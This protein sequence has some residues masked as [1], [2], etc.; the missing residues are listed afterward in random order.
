MRRGASFVS[1]FLFAASVVLSVSAP[2]R[3]ADP[4]DS[5]VVQVRE[6]KGEQGSAK[7]LFVFLDGTANNGMN[8]DAK[9]ATNVWLLYQRIFASPDRQV[10]AIYI[11]GVGSVD[12]PVFGSALGRGMELRILRGYDFIAQ[13]Y[14]QGDRV[15]IFGFSRGAFQARSLAGLISFVGVPASRFE[16]AREAID[17]GNAMLDLLKDYK[18]DDFVAALASRK[19]SAPPFG[20]LVRQ[21]LGMTMEPAEVQFLG[22]WDTVPGS[23]FKKYEGC[24]ETIGFWKRN[25]HSLPMISKGERY[26]LATYPSIRRVVHALSLD[27]KRSKFAPVVAC[28]PLDKT[29]SKVEEMWFPGAHA[30]V[31][32]GYSDS[33]GL[34]GISLRWMIDALATDYP[35]VKAQ[36]LE[37][38]AANATGLAHWSIGDRPANAGSD[39]EDRPEPPSDRIHSS[40]R[41]RKA[42]ANSKLRIKGKVEDRK[43]PVACADVRL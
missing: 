33:S 37:N 17:K 16:S 24:K 8:G 9:S 13:N 23:S 43:Y 1:A 19:G 4:D 42:V 38:I 5:P 15:Y 39:C 11:E 41:D 36:G 12:R 7:Q 34:P 18:D 40:A 29:A 35:L 27:E 30:D 14:R 10:A 31:G 22:I 2:A 20:E 26:K 3:A 6:F 21:E 25:F 32:G 28:A